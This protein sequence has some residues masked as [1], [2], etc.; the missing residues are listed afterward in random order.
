[1]NNNNANADRITAIKAMMRA[2]LER[3][4][5]PSASITVFGHST[6]YIQVRCI[7]YNTAQKWAELLYK[8]AGKAPTI[9]PSSWD[10]KHN[11]GTVLKPS[12][13]K[14]YL[15]AVSI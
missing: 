14:G 12:L 10:A 13:I 1:M 4:C 5:L 15:V 7:S 8:V 6:V 3:V 9:A 2:H 11:K